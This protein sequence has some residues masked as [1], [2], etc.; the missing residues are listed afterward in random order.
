MNMR[1]RL[2]KKR[3]KKEGEQTS[4]GHQEEVRDDSAATQNGDH[5]G[6]LR[7]LLHGSDKSCE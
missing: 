5:E 4:N 7:H 2:H 6:H 1:R 3:N